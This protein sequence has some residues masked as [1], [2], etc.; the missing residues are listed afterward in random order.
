MVGATARCR[1]RSRTPYSIAECARGSRRLRGAEQPAVL[2]DA[3]GRAI[4]P[5]TLEGD[6]PAG[7]PATAGDNRYIRAPRFLPPFLVRSGRGLRDLDYDAMRERERL[8]P[9]MPTQKDD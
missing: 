5:R 6:D 3:E 8:T 1:G 4:D 2:R 9:R 7:L